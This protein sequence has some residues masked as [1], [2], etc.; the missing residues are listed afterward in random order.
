[1]I[2]QDTKR[3]LSGLPSGKNTLADMQFSVRHLIPKVEELNLTEGFE[4][5]TT[6]R[7]PYKYLERIAE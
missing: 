4:V 3:Q 5:F 1:M 7:L 6:T 2:D